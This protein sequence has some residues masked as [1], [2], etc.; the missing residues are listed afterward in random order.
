MYKSTMRSINYYLNYYCDG[1][2]G[3]WDGIGLNEYLGL[4]IAAL[5]LG[6]WLLKADPLK[7]L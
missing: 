2:V 1:A 5:A 7:T 4:L 6:A 3:W